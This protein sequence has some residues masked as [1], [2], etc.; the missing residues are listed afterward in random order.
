[1]RLTANLLWGRHIHW[2]RRG[3]IYSSSKWG[4][5]L[6]ARCNTTNITRC[7][8]SSRNNHRE[9]NHYKARKYRALLHYNVVRYRAMGRAMG[10]VGGYGPA[11]E[12]SGC[13]SIRSSQTN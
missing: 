9:V 2:Y 4:A 5:S 12:S 10:K 3:L 11:R 7:L 6:W 1:M 8:T 13:G